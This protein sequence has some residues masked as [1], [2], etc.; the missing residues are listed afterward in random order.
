MAFRSCM[1]TKLK[2]NF[3]KAKRAAKGKKLSKS[4]MRST[5]KKSAKDCKGK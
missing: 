2:E 4:T 1:S 5:F 3:A